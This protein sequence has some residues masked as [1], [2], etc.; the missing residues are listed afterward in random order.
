MCVLQ[1]HV[2]VVISLSLSLSL[3]FSLPIL[4][5]HDRPAFPT[6]AAIGT[7]R[8]IPIKEVSHHCY[9]QHYSTVHVVAIIL[10]FLFLLDVHVLFIMHINN[11]NILYMF[12][13]AYNT[14]L[15]LIDW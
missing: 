5:K 13:Y 15:V 7:G 9:S 11:N 1:V 10:Y 12:M 8:T 6:T 2:Y 3:S 4:Q 14:P